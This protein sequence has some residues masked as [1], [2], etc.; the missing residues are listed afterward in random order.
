[1]K[2]FSKI[3]ATLSIIAILFYS[4]ESNHFFKSEKK[5]AS[6]L[7]GTWLRATI[8]ADEPAELWTFSD[9]KLIIVQGDSTT[10]PGEYTYSID[11]T[12]TAP[13]LK[14]E[15]STPDTVINVR[16]FPYGDLTSYALKWNIIQLDEKILDMAAENSTGTLVQIEFSKQ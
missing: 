4:C 1:M 6:N 3:T 9:G 10:Q 5:L 16:A 8:K 14:I 15:K 12:L 7:S 13:Y 11:A 2:P